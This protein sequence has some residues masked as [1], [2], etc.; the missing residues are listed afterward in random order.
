MHLFGHT[1]TIN[2]NNL[3]VVRLA[4]TDVRA[5]THAC[6]QN[7]PC[8]MPRIANACWSMTCASSWSILDPTPRFRQPNSIRWSSFWDQIC[9]S[10]CPT[11][12]PALTV[13]GQSHQ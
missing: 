4:A 5:I 10:Y 1:R 8:M 2:A 3:N 12:P 6:L 13:A 9:T 11:N 7:L